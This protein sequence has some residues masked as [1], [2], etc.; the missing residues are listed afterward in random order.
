[1]G[2]VCGVNCRIC[3]DSGEFPHS[4]EDSTGSGKLF[5]EGPTDLGAVVHVSEHALPVPTGTLEGKLNPRPKRRVRPQG[6]LHNCEKGRHRHSLDKFPY[7]SSAVAF[8]ARS[9]IRLEEFGRSSTGAGGTSGISACNSP[10]AHPTA[11]SAPD[12][13]LPPSSLAVVEGRPNFSGSWLCHATH[14]DMEALMS[15]LGIDWARRTAAAYFSYGVNTT[16]RMIEQRGNQLVINASVL[17]GISFVQSFI[18]GGGEQQ[19]DGPDGAV[20]LVPQWVHG[21]ILSVVQTG[22][23]GSP[24]SIWQQYFDGEDL[25]VKL[26]GPSCI[27][28]YFRF[29]RC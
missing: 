28:G 24:P 18:I 5:Q 14:G 19:T 23:D 20:V 11:S 12:C 22:L 15:D 25:V 6:E 1:M 17:P 7:S 4:F 29:G 13:I 3:Q 27:S 21:C 10:R 26:I 2:A 16:T 9:N 8:E